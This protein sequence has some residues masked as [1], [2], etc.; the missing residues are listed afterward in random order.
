MRRTALPAYHPQDCDLLPVIVLGIDR[1]PLKP[2]QRATARTGELSH[3]LGHGSQEQL[4]VVV[5]FLNIDYGNSVLFERGTSGL[6]LLLRRVPSPSLFSLLSVSS[7]QTIWENS[8][9][10]SR[11]ARD[12]TRDCISKPMVH[13]E[14]G[15]THTVR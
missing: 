9:L 10:L 5:L 11:G 12:S 15:T 13:S 3:M 8:H 4:E 7:A 2:I 1:V 14:T 6:E